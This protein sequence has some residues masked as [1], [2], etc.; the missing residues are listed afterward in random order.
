MADSSREKTASVSSYQRPEAVISHWAH[1][2]K[3]PYMIGP[4][5]RPPNPE[6]RHN[7]PTAEENVPNR[8]ELFLLGDGE[9]K[10]TEETDTRKSA[11]HS[12][13]CIHSRQTNTG[14]LTIMTCGQGS[15]L[16][17]FSH[18]IKRIIP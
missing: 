18:S 4:V 11:L 15:L 17:R 6:S 13:H 1:Y 5:M 14:L 3:E 12:P 7:R 10:V 2:R 9:K 16:L 8:F